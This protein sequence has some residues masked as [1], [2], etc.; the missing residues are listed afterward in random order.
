MMTG[1]LQDF[2]EKS[3]NFSNQIHSTP[4][5]Q[6]WIVK[7]VTAKENFSGNPPCPNC[8]ISRRNLVTLPSYCPND[9]ERCAD[10]DIFLQSVPKPCWFFCGYTNGVLIVSEFLKCGKCDTY[11]GKQQGVSHE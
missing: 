7:P 5:P 4:E 10:C 11:Q 8:G 2:P 9:A 3:A 6:A 1:I